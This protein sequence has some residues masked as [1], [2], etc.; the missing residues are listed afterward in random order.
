[1][2]SEE[3]TVTAVAMTPDAYQELGSLPAITGTT[4]NTLALSG[5]I[6]LVRNGEQAACIELPERR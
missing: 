1:M 5:R 4:W 6:L 2:L 3:G